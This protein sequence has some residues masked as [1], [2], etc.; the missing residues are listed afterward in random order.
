M[1]DPKLAGLIALFIVC[2]IIAIDREPK[3]Y[4][5]TGVERVE[6][7]CVVTAHIEPEHYMN[8]SIFDEEKWFTFEDEIL[9]YEDAKNNYRIILKK[10]PVDT[11]VKP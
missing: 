9:I 11:R 5:G 3:T 1:K 10:V 7:V 4:Y 8:I 2:L 6:P